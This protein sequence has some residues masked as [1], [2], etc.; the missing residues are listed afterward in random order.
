MSMFEDAME[1]LIDV[2]KT[3]ASVSIVYH[4]PDGLGELTVSIINCWVGQTRF[5]TN[6]GSF[7]RLDFSD[8]DYL[9][10]VDELTLD[11]DL[12]QPQEN[13]WIEQIINGKPSQQF[14]LIAPEGEPVWRYSDPQETLYRCH[15]KKMNLDI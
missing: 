12:V 5:R 3:E 15:C 1:E 2:L 6:V 9:I 10:P 4:R 14:K 11:G 8:R 7:S 13:D